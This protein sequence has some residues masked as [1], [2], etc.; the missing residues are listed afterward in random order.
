MLCFQQVTAVIHCIAHTRPKST[1]FSEGLHGPYGHASFACVAGRPDP[2]PLHIVAPLFW[3]R[4]KK[5][6]LSVPTM[7]L[8]SPK[9]R[10]Y[11]CLSLA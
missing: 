9:T 10:R 5:W 2:K 7:V 11:S 1:S 4:P 8:G 3:A 6:W